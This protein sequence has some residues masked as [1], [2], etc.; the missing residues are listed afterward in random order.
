[1]V[2]EESEKVTGNTHKIVQ[3]AAMEACIVRCVLMWSQ[4]SFPLNFQFL[5]WYAL[6]MV[7]RENRAHS[8]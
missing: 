1:M 7:P 3:R 8:K 2:E 4:L 6:V 5:E